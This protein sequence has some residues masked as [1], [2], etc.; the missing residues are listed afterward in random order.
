MLSFVEDLG[1]EL[2][3]MECVDMDA[4]PLLFTVGGGKPW[5]LG[6]RCKELTSVL[7]SL[8]LDDFDDFLPDLLDRRDGGRA[9]RLEVAVLLVSKS[10]WLS[11]VA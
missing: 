3:G 6:L 5:G 8:D 2:N 11:T 1:F 10:P 9:G 7:E 4:F